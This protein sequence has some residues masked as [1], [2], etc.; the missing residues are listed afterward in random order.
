MNNE[1]LTREPRDR[2]KHICLRSTTN[3]PDTQ[4]TKTPACNQ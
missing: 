1:P 4:N 2:C 3:T